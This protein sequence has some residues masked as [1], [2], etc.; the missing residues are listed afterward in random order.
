M[1]F[2]LRR[3]RVRRKVSS[4]SRKKYITYKEI[5]R[6]LVHERVAF[7]GA[8][9]NVS[10]NRIAIRNSRSRWGSCSKAGNLNFNYKIAL[11]PLGLVD[12]VIVHEICHLIEFNHSPN[13]W[14]HV[15]RAIPNHKLLRKELRMISRILK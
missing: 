12:Y 6:G 2:V 1:F 14:A 10:V 8:S 9:Y 11:L 7:W 5:A 13:F 15:S 4:T 3:R